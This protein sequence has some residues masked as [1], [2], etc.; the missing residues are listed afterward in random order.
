MSRGSDR[1]LGLNCDLIVNDPA[2]CDCA[3]PG[4]RTSLGECCLILD[5]LSIYLGVMVVSCYAGLTVGEAGI[6]S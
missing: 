6:K 1:F 3:L 2:V 5:G 4:D